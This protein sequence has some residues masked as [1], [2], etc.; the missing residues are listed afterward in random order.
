VLEDLEATDSLWMLKLTGQFSGAKEDS[1]LEVVAVDALDEPM[2]ALWMS[3]ANPSSHEAESLRG[4]CLPPKEKNIRRLH[5]GCTTFRIVPNQKSGFH[6]LTSAKARI[7]AAAAR[8]PSFALKLMVRKDLQDFSNR[9]RQHIKGCKALQSR[10]ED[11]PR[12]AFY[13]GIK[14]HLKLLAS[15]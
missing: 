9:L 5:G 6:L 8:M 14:H 1:I 15:A 3:M 11:S 13:Q 12:A 2:K 10:I 4:L 7:P